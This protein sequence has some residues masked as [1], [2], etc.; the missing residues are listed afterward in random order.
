MEV[1]DI[2]IVNDQNRVMKLVNR[3]CF[4]EEVL[5]ERRPNFPIRISLY[6]VD[7]EYVGDYIEDEVKRTGKKVDMKV[8][9]ELIRKAV[10]KNHWGLV[11]DFAYVGIKMGGRK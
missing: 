7:G 10:E 2:V 8:I 1:G 5:T 3:E 6:A 4:I 11:W 9:Q